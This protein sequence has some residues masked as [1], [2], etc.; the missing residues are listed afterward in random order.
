MIC[1]ACN[2]RGLIWK[3]LKG[4]DHEGRPIDDGELHI[5]LC[6]GEVCRRRR[7]WGA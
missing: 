6:M 4:I 5:T 3:R 1:T 7:G 2:N